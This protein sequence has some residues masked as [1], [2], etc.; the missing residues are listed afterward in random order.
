MVLA[1][2]IIGLGVTH[3]LQGVAGIVQNPGREKIY[4]V[5][6]VWVAT[7]FLRIIFWW[8]FQ[9]RLSE[10]GQWSFGLYFFVIVYAFL[11]FL[12]CAFLF[13][14][15]LAGHEGFEGYFYSSRAWFFGINLAGIV[16]DVIDSLFKGLAHFR[17][18]GL[19]YAILMVIWAILFAIAMRTRNKRF[20]AALAVAALVY[21]LVYPAI[22][23]NVVQ[24][25]AS[26]AK[27]P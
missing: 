3:L 8:W 13:P 4:W 1:S 7:I 24:G 20:H 2:V 21:L 15:D 12:A 17:A 26:T 18:L 25:A 19:S 6:L 14:R 10:T 22:S 27:H 23:F 5:H 9:F 16:I 11:I